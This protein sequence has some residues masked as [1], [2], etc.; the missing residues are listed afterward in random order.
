MDLTAGLNTG[1]EDGVVYAFNFGDDG[2]EAKADADTTTLAGAADGNV[3][4][5][6]LTVAEFR[7]PLSCVSRML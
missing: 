2:P 3:I 6:W 7:E 4:D 1:G 5:G